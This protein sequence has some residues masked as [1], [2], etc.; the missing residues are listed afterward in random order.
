MAI[1]VFTESGGKLA[2]RLQEE[3]ASYSG[4]SIPVLRVYWSAG[5]RE[6]WRAQSGEALWEVVEP[7]GWRAEIGG[8]R[9]TPQRRIF[10]TTKVVEGVRVLL[11]PEAQAAAG[12]LKVSAVQ[13]RLV[14]SHEGI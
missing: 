10:E 13:E 6:N 4:P 5:E 1:L 11:E 14:V 9:D 8:W 2:S 7:A 3:L 12:T